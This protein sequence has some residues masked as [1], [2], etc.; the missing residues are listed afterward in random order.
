MRLDA[1]IHCMEQRQIDGIK[2]FDDLLTGK[3]LCENRRVKAVLR[4]AVLRIFKAIARFDF[5]VQ[6]SLCHSHI[7]WLVGSDFVNQTRSVYLFGPPRAGKRCLPITIKAVCAGRNVYFIPCAD[8]PPSLT[9]PI[10]RGCLSRE[11][12]S[13]AAP[14]CLS[15]VRWAMFRPCPVTKTRFSGS[16]VPAMESAMTPPSNRRFAEQGDV[17]GDP[18][19]VAAL[20]DCLHHYAVVDRI[21]G[22]SYRVRHHADLSLGGSRSAALINLPQAQGRRS[23]PPGP[24]AGLRIANQRILP[25]AADREN[26]Q[27]CLCRSSRGRQKSYRARRQSFLGTSYSLRTML[28][29][30][31]RKAS[32]GHIFRNLKPMRF[33]L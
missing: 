30:E 18:V 20:F 13:F 31:A 25:L 2:V 4:V 19:I 22:S 9:K 1:T 32:V 8:L 12:G 5:S 10:A 21:E 15:P 3:L 27:A 24:P 26:L 23:Y 11:S 17:L 29:R 16:S 7:N 33:G 28:R 6:P 14:S